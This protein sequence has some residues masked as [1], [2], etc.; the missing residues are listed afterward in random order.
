M[1]SCLAFSWVLEIQNQVLWFAQQALPPPNY[2]HR[3]LS[4]IASYLYSF[5]SRGIV[6][7]Q[8]DSL[9]IYLSGFLTCPGDL[10]GMWLASQIHLTC[11]TVEL[12][13]LGPELRWPQGNTLRCRISLKTK[14]CCLD[15][16]PIQPTCLLPVGHRT[17]AQ[18][19]LKAIF[20]TMSREEALFSMTSAVVITL[21]SNI[22]EIRFSIFRFCSL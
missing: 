6:F 20:E 12:P 4:S 18:W 3:P 19:L 17:K 16:K 11:G 9:I 2:L 1:P 8:G 7:G 14:F 22:P 10:L 21:W 5:L 13:A 15:R